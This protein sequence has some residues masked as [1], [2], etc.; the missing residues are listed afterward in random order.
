MDETGSRASNIFP[1][2]LDDKG[3]AVL[4]LK[5]VGDLS[6]LS[7][8]EGRAGGLADADDVSR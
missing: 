7:L 1:F 8:D 4:A 6:I 5:E 3:D 2:G